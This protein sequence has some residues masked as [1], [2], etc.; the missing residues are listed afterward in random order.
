MTSNMVECFNNVLKGVRSLPVTAILK[1]TF[2]KLNE[3]F[4]RH[5]ETTAKWIGEKKEYPDKVDDWLRFQAGK[6]AH[7]QII[8]CND[9][10]MIYQVD[11]PG[12]TTRDGVAYGGVAY[13]VDLKNRW[14]QCERPHKYHWSCSHLM[15]AAKARNLHVSE[16]R[17]VWL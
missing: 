13:K 14:C 16:G 12:G 4:L 15:T 17:T 7:Q 9:K 3:Y 6:S 1:Y 8:R 5:S 10:E 2:F 11:E